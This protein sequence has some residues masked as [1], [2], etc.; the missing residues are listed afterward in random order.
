MKVE[1]QDPNNGVEDGISS[2]LGPESTGVGDGGE[3]AHVAGAEAPTFQ[4]DEHTLKS[5][6]QFM[7][8]QAFQATANVHFYPFVPRT[9]RLMSRLIRR[10]GNQ[11]RVWPP[12]LHSIIYRHG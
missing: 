12:R 4:F 1:E 7:E 5:L 6:Q 8:S 9:V 3:E 10:Q 11:D 2:S